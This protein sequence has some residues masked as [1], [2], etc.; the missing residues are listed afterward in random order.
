[1][2]FYH[3][4]SG[5]K[6]RNRA[7]RNITLL[8]EKGSEISRIPPFLDMTVHFET[9][10][11]AGYSLLFFTRDFIPIRKT[12]SPICTIL[13]WKFWTDMKRRHSLRVIPFE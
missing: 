5:I 1:M 10:R 13:D 3:K 12:Y 7:E 9:F 8:K 4:R 11:T 2:L 6:S